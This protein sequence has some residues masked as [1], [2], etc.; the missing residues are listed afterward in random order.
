MTKKTDSS[1][2]GGGFHTTAEL[3]DMAM[4]LVDA[5]VDHWRI[6]WDYMRTGERDDSEWY[7][8]SERMYQAQ[9]AL[10]DATRKPPPKDLSKNGARGGFQ[11]LAER[12]GAFHAT[13][14]LRDMAR[15]AHKRGYLN[16]AARFAPDKPPEAYL[17]AMAERSADAFEELER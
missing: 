16:G 7:A 17:N 13:V 12:G 15:A 8:S 9:K 4:E 2:R 11:L 10:D 1:E 14:E 3:R 5:K 6:F